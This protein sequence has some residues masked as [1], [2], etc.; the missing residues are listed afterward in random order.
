MIQINISNKVAY[1]L[2]GL[3]VVVLVAGV[4]IAY[5]SI[6]NPG[7]GGNE[8][9]I[10]TLRGDEMTLQDAISAGA[11]G[12]GSLSC[13]RIESACGDLIDD[14]MSCDGFGETIVSA[15][16]SENHYTDFTD[17]QTVVF[18]SVSSSSIC[19]IICCTGVD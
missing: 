5:N 18:D 11:L 15:G 12:G 6:P 1:L 4:G 9:Q 7:H 14:T 3:L 2:V 19:H 13:R 16:A 8:I 17:E 10:T